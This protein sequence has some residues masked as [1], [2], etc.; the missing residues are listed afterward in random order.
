MINAL[1]GIFSRIACLGK[2]RVR[3][4]ANAKEYKYQVVNQ[5]FVHYLY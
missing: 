4:K 3:R 1:N 2:K 5:C